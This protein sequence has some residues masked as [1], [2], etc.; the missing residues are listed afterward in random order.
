[1]AAGSGENL[2]ANQEAAEHKA[3]DRIEGIK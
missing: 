2:D 3:S 1:M